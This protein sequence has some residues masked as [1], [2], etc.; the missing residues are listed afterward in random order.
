MHAYNLGTRQ[1]LYHGRCWGRV[2]V[3]WRLSRSSRLKESKER[4]P[5][6]LADSTLV[7][8]ACKLDGAFGSYRCIGPRIWLEEELLATAEGSGGSVA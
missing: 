4:L 6:C 7:W 3:M 2:R 5:P 8:A 1:G